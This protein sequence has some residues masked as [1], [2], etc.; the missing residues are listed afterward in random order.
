MRTDP[1]VHHGRHFGRT[2]RAFCRVQA[3]IKEGLSIDVQL[4]LGDVSIDELS[5]M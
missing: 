1:L 4:E 2:I 3:L 5:E